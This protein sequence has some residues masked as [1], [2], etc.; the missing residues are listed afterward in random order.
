M[1]RSPSRAVETSRSYALRRPRITPFFSV[2]VRVLLSM[3]QI[4][5]YKVVLL[6]EGPFHSRRFLYLKF[7]SA[8]SSPPSPFFA[9][10]FS[11]FFPEL[12][13][14]LNSFLRRLPGSFFSSSFLTSLSLH[15][16]SSA[17]TFELSLLLH[18]TQI[19]SFS[20]HFLLFSVVV[21]PIGLP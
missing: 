17:S 20:F 6:G 3:A 1:T 14:L 2:L 18:S 4:R 19:S 10:L 16:L 12:Y 13:I 21:Y 15:R 9:L 11:L 5:K 8:F 7:S